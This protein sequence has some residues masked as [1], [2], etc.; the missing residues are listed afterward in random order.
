M[1]TGNRRNNDKDY[2]VIKFRLHYI[3]KTL[4]TQASSAPFLHTIRLDPVKLCMTDLA[5]PAVKAVFQRSMAFQ[6][7]QAHVAHLASHNFLPPFFPPLPDE[8]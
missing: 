4:S 6:S 8:R 1:V 5:D 7:L 2:N 3:N